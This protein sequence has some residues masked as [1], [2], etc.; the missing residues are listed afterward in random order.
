MDIN[1]LRGIATLLA[2]AAFTGICLWAYSSRN[3]PRFDEAARLPFADDA[4]HPQAGNAALN[5]R[6]TTP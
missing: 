5:S 1:T 4:E 6:E 3:K 2:F